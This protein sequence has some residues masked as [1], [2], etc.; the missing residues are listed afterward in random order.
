MRGEVVLL[1]RSIVIKG[2]TSNTWNGQFLTTDTTIFNT[3]GTSV[4]F[5]GITTLNNVEFYKMGQ[6]DNFKAALRFEGSNLPSTSAAFSA[7]E[8]CV[9]HEAAGW[10]VSVVNSSNI[11]LKNIDVFDAT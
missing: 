3:D 6:L 1:T 4:T 8:D 11:R 10:G 5:Q 2:D 7:V 9:I